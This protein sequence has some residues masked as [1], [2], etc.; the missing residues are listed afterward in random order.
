VA[1]YGLPYRGGVLRG[2]QRFKR[3]VA[4]LQ[5]YWRRRWGAFPIVQIL[6]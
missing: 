2:V 1:V 6:H 5:R 4:A 3:H